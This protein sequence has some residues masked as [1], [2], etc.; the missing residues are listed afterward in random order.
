[1]LITN[2][3]TIPIIPLGESIMKNKTNSVTFKEFL[4]RKQV[5]ITPKIYLIDA[6]GAMAF[7]LFAS[8]LIGT[9]FQTFGEKTGIAIFL[10]IAGYAKGA[11]GAALGVSIAVK[12]NPAA[13]KPAFTVSI[14][15]CFFPS[16]SS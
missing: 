4:K 14:T 12:S 9:I 13:S 15:S 10:T 7:G 11:T 16:P 2:V 3:L 5:N 6:L 1:M 8:L